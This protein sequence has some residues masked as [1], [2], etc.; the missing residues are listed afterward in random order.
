MVE[1]IVPAGS[2]ILVKR[3]P[4]DNVS[5]GGVIIPEIAKKKPLEG[6]VL[7]LGK[8]RLLENGERIP[9]KVK[10]G[11][12][13]VFSSFVDQ[14]AGVSRNTVGEDLMVIEEQ[15]ILAVVETPEKDATK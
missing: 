14:C 3:L 12:R 11:D 7:A 5:E 6:K 4:A 13:I 9:F 1:R 2:H 8:G 15:D 10:V